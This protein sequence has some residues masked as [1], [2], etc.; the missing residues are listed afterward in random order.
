MAGVQ[1]IKA[2][3]S[4]L[5]LG[6]IAIVQAVGKDGFQPT[7]LLAP[8]QS[9]EFNASIKPVLAGYKD[10]MHEISDLKFDETVDLV[11]SLAR[12]LK[13]VYTEVKVASDKIKEQEVL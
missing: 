5:K 1:N 11:I 10:L 4:M 7:D 9:A 8:I 13:D 3:G 2:L 6:S 12:G